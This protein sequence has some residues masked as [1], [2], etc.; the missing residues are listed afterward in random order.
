MAKRQ[1]ALDEVRDE[2]AH[3]TSCPLYRNAT[4]TVFGEGPANAPLM[5]VGEQPGDHEDREGHPFVGPAGRLLDKALEE[6]GICRADTYLT[7][8]VKHFKNEQRGKRRLH[9]RP[10]T[11]EIDVCKW[12]LKLELGIVRPR[13]V[14]ALGATALRSLLGRAASVESL[15]GRAGDLDEG[16]ALFVTV[17]PSYLLRIPDR[18]AKAREFD[19][20]V[21][22]LS[23][24]AS[25]ADAGG[26]SHARHAGHAAHHGMR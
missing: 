3:C 25:I 2:A 6:A 7:N 14:V 16:C 10:N 8:A 22:D 26:R 19:R 5:L 23:L 15:R 4:Q 17:H 21:A 9:K 24:A 1:E 18:A 11:G 12:W 20:F 13:V